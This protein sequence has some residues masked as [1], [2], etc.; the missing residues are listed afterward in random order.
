MSDKATKYVVTRSL[1]HLDWETSLHIGGDVVDQVP[2][3]K[4]SRS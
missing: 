4:A 2:R 1:D 3:L